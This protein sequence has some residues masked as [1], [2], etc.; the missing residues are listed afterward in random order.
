MLV[1]VVKSKLVLN[2]N[3]YKLGD[4]FEC[5]DSEAKVFIASG[6]VVKSEKNV[7]ATAS[8]PQPSSVVPEHKPRPASKA[9]LSGIA[10]PTDA[11]RS[12]FGGAAKKS[13]AKAKVSEE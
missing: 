1:K 13:T 6:L 12:T 8:E 5:R 4:V 7:T 2:T 9:P 3:I 10:K 11:F